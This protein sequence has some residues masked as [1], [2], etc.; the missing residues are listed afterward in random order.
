MPTYRVELNAENLL[1]EVEGKTAKHGFFTFRVLEADSPDAAEAAAV[2]MIQDDE[3]LSEMIQNSATDPPAINV[4][5][6][7]EI[8]AADVGTQPGRIWYEMSP[9]RWWQFWK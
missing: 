6:I 1:V 2:R 3:S 7:S 4:E 5:G 9:K 8:D